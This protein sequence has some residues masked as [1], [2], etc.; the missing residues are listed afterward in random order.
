[1]PYQ[2]RS[3]FNQIEPVIKEERDGR[4]GA[5]SAGCFTALSAAREPQPRTRGPAASA[6]K[7]PPRRAALG[8]RLLYN[9]Y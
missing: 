3:R 2:Q 7:I 8:T 1:M 5:R 9:K 4:E 6:A